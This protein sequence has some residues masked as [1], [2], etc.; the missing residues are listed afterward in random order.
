M[1]LR[2][3]TPGATPPHTPSLLVLRALGLGDLLAG[4]PALRAVRRAFPGHELVLAA[5]AALRDAAAATRCVDTF[6]P[7]RAPGRAVPSL[8]AWRGPPPDLAIDLHGNGAQSHDALAAL[9]PRRLWSFARPGLPESAAPRWRADEHERARWCRF[10]RA[11]GIA[12]DP[13]E[14]RLPPPATHS[15]APG[16]VVVHPGADAP[17][18]C[19][20]AIR[21]AQVVRR[22]RARGHR[23]VLTG[24]PGERALLSAVASRAG[25][26]P[27][28]VFAGRLPFATLSALLAHAVLLVSGDTGPAHLAYA[29]GTASVTLFGPVPPSR[30]GPPPGPHVALWHPGPPGDPHATAPDPLL[31]RIS[32][33]EVVDAALRLV[34]PAPCPLRT[35]QGRVHV[36]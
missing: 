23:V 5:P 18:R 24:G 31:L 30:W 16:A 19:W 28:D 14:L 21:Y 26:G 13:G 36:R 7:T 22:L 17:A 9:A 4:V 2:T 8:A 11:Y 32:V 25:V 10:L 1:R 20:P 12:A 6:L 35:P 34:T 29:H 33:H 27:R 3:T 15:P